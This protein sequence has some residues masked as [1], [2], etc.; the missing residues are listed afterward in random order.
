MSISK[1]LNAMVAGEEEA[2]YL[3]VN[4]EMMKLM[5]FVVGTLVTA[6]AVSTSGIIGFVG[7]IMPHMSRRLFGSDHKISMPASA[8]LGG[9]FIVACDTVARTAFT[10]SEMPI[11]TITALI[12]APIFI[13]ILR[14]RV[15]NV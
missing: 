6:I 8:I 14:R 2:A 9:T 13:Y 12:G 1:Y 4:V 11:G 3:G 5:I 7:L 15:Q 10:P